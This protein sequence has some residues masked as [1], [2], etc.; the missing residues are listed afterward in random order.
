MMHIANNLMKFLRLDIFLTTKCHIQI[1][2]KWMI[3]WIQNQNHYVQLTFG[4]I[5]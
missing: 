3:E 4:L 5:I 1:Q 2:K